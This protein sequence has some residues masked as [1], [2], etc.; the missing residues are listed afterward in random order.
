MHS[1]FSSFRFLIVVLSLTVAG[2][3]VVRAADGDPLK[4]ELYQG[5]DKQYHWRLKEGDMILATAG[6][7]YSDK[8]SC[9]RAID[10]VKKG[11]ESDKHKFEIYEDNAKA[12]RWRLKAVNGQ[13][14][15]AANKGFKEKAACEK[16]VEQIKQG[17]AKAE[18]V[19]VK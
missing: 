11:L 10:G 9:K 12:Y 3:A 2:P 15:A 19:E 7:G 1:R 17:V 14:V 4:F 16:V 8:S 6:Q 5:Q 13:T 18:V